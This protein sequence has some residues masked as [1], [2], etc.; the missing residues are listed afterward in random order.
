MVARH[1]YGE[2]STT[3]DLHTDSGEKNREQV[4]LRARDGY[5][6]WRPPFLK[7]EKKR[8]RNTQTVKTA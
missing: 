5:E 3:P 4:V 1:V 6:R 7:Q 8:G 2:N